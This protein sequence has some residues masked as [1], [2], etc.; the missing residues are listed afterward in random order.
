MILVTGGLGF[1]GCNLAHYLAKKQ[2]KFLLAQR[3]I[4]SVPVFLEPMVGKSLEMSQC[5]ILDPT[6]LFDLFKR[7]PIDSVIHMAATYGQKGKVYQSIHLNVTGTVNVLEACRIMKIDK[8]TFIS[9]HT[10]YQRGQIIH[11]EDED[12][13]LESAH[14]ISLTKKA[15]EMICNY[16]SKEY[17]LGIYIVRPSQVY[18][19]LYS[20]GINPLKRMLENAIAGKPVELLDVSPE[21]GNNMLYVKDCSRAIGMV[22]L[23]EK[24]RHAIYNVG[25]EYLTFGRMAEV[26][27]EIMPSSQIKFEREKECRIVNAMYLNCDRLNNEFGFS[28]EF[29]FNKGIEDYIR[30]LRFQEY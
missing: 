7:F 25:G 14:L 9:S 1:L 13:P 16:Y 26:I 27:R 11:R 12:L 5:D 15:C 19:P 24:P 23:A 21:E 2:C 17:G 28:P 6:N 30:W 20:S 4:G 22:H 3:R 18:G 8:V 29:S 10:V